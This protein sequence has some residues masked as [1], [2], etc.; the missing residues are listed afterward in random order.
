MEQISIVWG[1]WEATGQLAIDV[2][3]LLAEGWCIAETITT[4]DRMIFVL[5]KIGS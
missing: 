4:D 2:N 5:N 1:L 3:E